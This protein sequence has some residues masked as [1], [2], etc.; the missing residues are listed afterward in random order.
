MVAERE[1]FA[2]WQRSVDGARVVCV[3]ESGIVAGGRVGYGYGPRGERCEEHAPYRKGRRTSLLGWIGLGRG[4]LVAIE[5]SVDGDLFER[6]VRDH[7]APRLDAGD[8]VVWDNHSIHRR[9]VLRALIEARGASLVPQPRYSPEFN[10]SEEMWSKVKHHVRRARAD[11]T[12]ALTDA[13]RSAVAALT[14]ED[15]SGWLRH[16]GYRISPDE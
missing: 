15:S 13:L 9:P 4:K 14:W 16:A 1:A 2:K 11:T 3:D 6:F 10:A 5:D 8:I 7:L 12:E